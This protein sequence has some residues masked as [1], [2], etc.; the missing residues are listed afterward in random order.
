MFKE[1]VMLLTISNDIPV[2]DSVSMIN[3]LLNTPILK[4]K[5]ANGKT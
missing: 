1:T 5:T 2:K 3:G 4:R